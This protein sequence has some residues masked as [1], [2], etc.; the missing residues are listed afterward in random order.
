MLVTVNIP[1]T[2][3]LVDGHENDCSKNGKQGKQKECHAEEAE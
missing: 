3:E 1:T 2:Y